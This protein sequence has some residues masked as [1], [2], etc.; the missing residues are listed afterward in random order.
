MAVIYV[1]IIHNMHLMM[2]AELL[3]LEMDD[4]FFEIHV[5]NYL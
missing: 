2:S 1:I 5:R 3:R 4:F